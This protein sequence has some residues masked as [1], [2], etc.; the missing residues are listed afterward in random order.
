[1]LCRMKW[2]AD[3]SGNIIV[4]STLKDLAGKMGLSLSTLEGIYYRKRHNNFIKIT[5]ITEPE[6]KS[7][8]IKVGTFLVNFS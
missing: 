5:K 3:V 4:G 6:K 2:E 8:E 7:L 1:M